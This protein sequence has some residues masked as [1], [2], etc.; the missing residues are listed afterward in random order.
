MKY[1]IIFDGEWIGLSNEIYGSQI[2]YK[3]F[4]LCE[5]IGNI[6]DNH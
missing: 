2:G 4:D 6:Y 3:E 5:V 1:E